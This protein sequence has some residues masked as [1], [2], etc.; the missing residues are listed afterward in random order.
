MLSAL[1]TLFLLQDS[2]YDIHLSRSLHWC[3]NYQLKFYLCSHFYCL[4]T[5]ILCDLPY[6]SYIV[7]ASQCCRSST[8]WVIFHQFTTILGPVMPLRHL[9][10]RCHLSTIHCPKQLQHFCHQYSQSLTKLNSMLLLDV[11]HLPTSIAHIAF[12]SGA[13]HSS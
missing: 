2:Q 12:S 10:L 13:Y 3:G 4:T 9:S 7:L 11:V 6:L 1:A 8:A 5:I